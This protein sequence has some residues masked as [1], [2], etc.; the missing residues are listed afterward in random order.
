MH[1]DSHEITLGAN[2]IKTRNIN[3]DFAFNFSKIDNYVDE[4]APGVES[5]FLGGFVEPQVRAG[6]G[7]KYPVLFGKSYLRDNNGRKVVDEKGMPMVGEEKVIGTVSPDFR[8]GF[9]TNLDVY[10]FRISAVL[11]W[12]QGGQMYAATPGLMDMYGMSQKSADYRNRGDFIFPNSVKIDGKDANGDN[13]YVPNDIVIK[14]ENIQNYFT[15]ENN[16]S[17]SM[18]KGNSFVKLREISVSYPVFDK[19]WLNIRLNLFA[20]NILLWTELEGIDPET[21][22]GNN[23]MG[24]AFERFSLPNTFSYGLGLNVKF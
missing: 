17:E 23:N 10:K 12:K 21:A 9:N 20:R 3:W 15:A 11:D 16:V 18:I 4:L 14:K 24:G 13:I 7:Y 8:L 22:Q 2:P 6:I 1:T 5:I 19:S